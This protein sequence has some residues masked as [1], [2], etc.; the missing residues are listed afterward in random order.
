MRTSPTDLPTPRRRRR[1]ELSLAALFVVVHLVAPIV[2]G[3]C[4]PITISPMFCDQPAQCC[5]YQVTDGRGKS[6]DPEIFGLHLVYDGNPP[7]LGMG[8]T[9]APTLHPYCAPCSQEKVSHHVREVIQREQIEGPVTIY[10][11]DLIPRD[12]KIATEETQWEV[13]LETETAPD[14]DEEAVR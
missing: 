10:K 11:R 7:G 6:L 4:Y 3:E 5:T 2:V 12:H 13:R 8:I 9:P 14:A 1:L